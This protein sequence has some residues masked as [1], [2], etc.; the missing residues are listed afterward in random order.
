MSTPCCDRPLPGRARP[1][2]TPL[3]IVINDIGAVTYVCQRCTWRL[4]GRCWR[5]GAVRE[6]SHYMASFC[7]S[8]RA[9]VKRV[10]IQ[11]REQRPDVIE[12]RRAHDARRWRQSAT[13][14]R[15]LNA[16]CRRWRAKQ[17]NAA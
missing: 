9:V 8:C 4:S 1:C 12:H 3:R 11:R 7:A 17:R 13:R 6:N 10:R 16:A 14:R 5:C 2:R 15:S